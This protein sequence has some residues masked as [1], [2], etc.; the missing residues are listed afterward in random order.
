MS[1]PTFPPSD[2]NRPLDYGTAMPMVPVTDPNARTWGMIGHLAALSALF[3]GIGNIVGPLIV[4]LIKKDEIP[5]AGDQAK[6]SLNF[7]I[8]W[9][10]VALLLS[11]TICIGIGIVILPAIWVFTV[12][13]AIVGAVKA[14]NG[15]W[16][17]Y[18]LT[19]RLV[20]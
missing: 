9:T 18:P 8:T 3:T 19:L 13:M 20:K 15:E 14:N 16:Y 6:E 1:D 11:W 17:R 2:P 10:I 12:I 7:Q 4:W 5:F